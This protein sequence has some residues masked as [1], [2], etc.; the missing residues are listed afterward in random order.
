MFEI[1]YPQTENITK[2]KKLHIYMSVTPDA[3]INDI[4]FYEGEEKFYILKA[5]FFFKDNN[6]YDLLINRMNDGT[7]DWIHADGMR[8]TE[9][10]RW[11]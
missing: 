9:L 7:F 8:L 3:Q 6:H 5:I 4:A 1:N 2:E 10:K 11:G